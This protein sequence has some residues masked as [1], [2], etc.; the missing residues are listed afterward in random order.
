MK[1]SC[2]L[3]DSQDLSRHPGQLAY[4]ALPQKLVALVMCSQQLSNKSIQAGR[5]RDWCFCLKECVAPVFVESWPAIRDPNR[6]KPLF[7]SMGKS[8]MRRRQECDTHEA[9]KA[10]ERDIGDIGVHSTWA[11]LKIRRPKMLGF[12][13][14]CLQSPPKYGSPST[15]SGQV[16]QPAQI[17]LITRQ[18]KGGKSPFL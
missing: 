16:P 6:R 14:A 4:P 10:T 3:L 15:C 5:F 11:C 12:L 8:S 2:P 1:T 17:S 18:R 7:F 9:K 13:L